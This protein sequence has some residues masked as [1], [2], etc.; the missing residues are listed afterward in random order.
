M[1]D[2]SR[3]KKWGWSVLLKSE[4]KNNNANMDT[5]EGILKSEW[6]NKITRKIKNCEGMREYEKVNAK[7]KKN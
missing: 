5:E 2:A 3:N 6:K 4:C 1:K 7:K